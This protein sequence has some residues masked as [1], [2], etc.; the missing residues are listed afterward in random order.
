MQ[1]V[2]KREEDIQ[3]MFWKNCLKLLKKEKVYLILLILISLLT[4]RFSDGYQGNKREYFIMAICVISTVLLLILYFTK[5][6]EIHN[7]AFISIF[8]LGFLSLMVQPILNIPDEQTHF[9]RAEIISEGKWRINPDEQY[10]DTIKSVTD[11]QESFSQP[12][13]ESI[14]V[15]GKKI[16]YT[17]EKVGHVAASNMTILYIP[18][19][20]GIAVAK[21][22]NMNAIWMMWFARLGNLFSYIILIRSAI[23][24]APRL[25]CFLFFI[26]ILPMSVQ[27]A[28]SCSVD[29]M[30]NG[31]AILF[32]A[33]FLRLRY[34]N[35]QENKE[36]IVFF[37]LALFISVAKVTN[38]FLAGL[39]LLVPYNVEKGKYKGKV[40]KAVMIIGVIAVG[41][42]HYY[43][44]TT[45]APAIDQIGYLKSM[46]I[47]S[48]AQIQYILNNT[49]EWL[50]Y[51]VMSAINQT[52]G[53]VLQLNTYGSLSY[54]CPILS[55]VM[56]YLFGRMCT[57]EDGVNFSKIERILIILMACGIYGATCLALYLGWTPVGSNGIQG[58]QGRYFIPMLMLLGLEVM[59]PQKDKLYI[60]YKTNI[61]LMLIM[62]SSMIIITG[63]KYY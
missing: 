58:V 35:E 49:E 48:K 24:I 53:Y 8:V 9:A 30:I 47:N 1:V 32:V 41:V 25:K 22:L 51:F 13:T 28:A 21:V 7:Y 11:L 4:F 45:F 16:D 27:Q 5:K 20:I 10:F 50:Y 59:M 3:R 33:L 42:L 17:P 57:Q 40:I 23:K 18:Q 26:S 6:I 54:S 56:V 43:Y 2:L 63:V 12:I 36:W 37:L 31:S 38:I 34:S 39:I 62:T 55:L 14:L 46:N 60:N 19:A 29:S 44:T 15:K 52:W 61:L